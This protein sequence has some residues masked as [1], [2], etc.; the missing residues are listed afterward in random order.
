MYIYVYI[1]VSGL[2]P[3]TEC[4]TVNKHRSYTYMCNHIYICVYEVTA[5]KYGQHICTA[6][7]PLL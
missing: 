3:P 5:H 7:E 6:S 2:C 1:Y 4:L